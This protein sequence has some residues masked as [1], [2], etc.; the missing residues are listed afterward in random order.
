MIVEGKTREEL[1]GAEWFE[2]LA[3]AV[4]Q[5]PGWRLELVLRP[6]RV[7]EPLPARALVIERAEAARRLWHQGET[8]PALLIAWAAVEG[9]L[10]LLAASERIDGVN[11][12]R[13]LKELYAEGLLGTAQLA[14]L[15]AAHT[16]RNRVAHGLPHPAVG[17]RV[18]V[19]R[20]ADLAVW[21]VDERYATVD[22]APG[23][24]RRSA[25]CRRDTP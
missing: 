22:E 17:G 13:M 6:R 10:R 18:D 3:D 9:A 5:Q 20:L 14:T 8:E 16:V 15:R 23:T 2:R 4:R 24:S 7:Q 25:A 11:S 1:V 12:G 21:L 19:T